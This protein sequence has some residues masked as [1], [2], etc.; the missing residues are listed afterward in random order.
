MND[1]LSIFLICLM[2]TA[3]SGS[4]NAQQNQTQDLPLPAIPATLRTPHER[5]SYLLAHFWDSMSFADTLRS[6]NPGFME[7]NLVNYL[8]LFPH[9]PAEARTEA[10]HLLMQR[11]EADKPAYLLLAELAEKYL[12]T[13]GSPMQSEEHFIPFLEAIAHT[14]L[15]NDTEKSRPRFLL[16]AALKNRPG[17]IATDFAYFT[18]EGDHRTLHTTPSAHCL[19]LM[20]Y[21]PDCT[22]CRQ[23]I[24]LLHDDR[25]FKQMLHDGLLTVLAINTENTPETAPR[26]EAAPPCRKQTA[27]RLDGRNRLSHPHRQ[28]TVHTPLHA[29]PLPA[30][31]RKTRP[32]KRSTAGAG[33]LTPCERKPKS[34]PT[35]RMI[36]NPH[37]LHLITLPPYL[38]AFPVKL[39]FFYDKE[40]RHQQPTNRRHVILKHPSSHRT[41]CRLQHIGALLS[42]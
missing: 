20:F 25:L 12:Y 33:P 32:P 27:H 13:I 7:Q 9:A 35:R 14:P 4:M 40:K 31:Q 23:T 10:V 17:T 21:N 30:G 8:S 29:H 36:S 16:S 34:V 3:I 22:H 41:S 42:K 28:R 24:A 19:L 6:R 11:A 39:L 18:P 1:R 38:S 5:A 15:L 37:S 26:P 2:L